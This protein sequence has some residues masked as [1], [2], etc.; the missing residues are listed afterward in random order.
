MSRLGK[1]GRLPLYP[2][3][4]AVY[5]ALVLLNGNSN[6]LTAEDFLPVF[7]ILIAAVGAVFGLFYL[8]KRQ[9]ARC[10]ALTTLVIICLIYY[11]LVSGVFKNL[12]V[13]EYLWPVLWIAVL[14][15]AGIAVWRAKSE[16]KAVALIGNVFTLVLIGGPLVNVAKFYYAANPIREAVAT[17][18][19]AQDD[20]ALSAETHG[21]LRDIYYIVPDRYASADQLDAVY[22]FQNAAFLE[23]LS[24]RGFH[25]VD[26]AS[27]NY[28]RTP[29]SLAS[30]LNMNHLMQV[31]ETIGDPSYDWVPLYQMIESNQVAELLKHQGYRFYQLGS[32]WGPTR[33]NDT[34]DR[35]IN[36][37]A[38]PEL[39]RI[40]TKLSLLPKIGEGLGLDAFDERRQQC[41]RVRHKF[42]QL[43]EIAREEGEPKFVFAHFLV[44]HP[45]FVFDRDGNC[46]NAETV[47]QRSRRDNYT[48]QVEFTNR[49]ILDLID[50]I[51]EATEGRAIIVL[52][53][54]EG[55]WPAR[56]ARDEI[57]GF[58][59]DVSAVSWPEA[60]RVELREK[61][62]ILHALYLPDGGSEE[63][64]AGF[65]PV[66]TFRVILNRYF[67][68]ELPLLP[69]RN[70]VFNNNADLYSFVDVTTEVQ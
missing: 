31:G 42:Q 44:P 24:S 62:R 18:L 22:D 54:D 53:S 27:A 37:S 57:N 10:A 68:T 26:N 20:L 39:F 25:I 51:R 67:G 7:A 56:Y 14:T 35:N 29:H 41:E 52:Q 17:N 12:A 8:V 46:L 47:S 55:P 9:A 38:E 11:G 40:L 6:R 49:R 43:S 23:E 19:S 34:A 32:W 5:P 59:I 69:D 30:S 13:P 15:T 60:T 21:P 16:F 2:F 58:G 1:I 64:Y 33:H 48:D 65:T 63:I 4:L 70:Y 66:N 61:M 50:T 28:P 36:F 3:L 45:P